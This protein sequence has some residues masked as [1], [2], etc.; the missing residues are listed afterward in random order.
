MLCWMGISK[1]IMYILREHRGYYMCMMGI[2]TS[3]AKGWTGAFLYLFIYVV[4]LEC[5]VNYIAY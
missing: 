2:D 5:V 1:L 3:T 4:Y